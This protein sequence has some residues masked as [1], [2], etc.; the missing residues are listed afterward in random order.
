MGYHTNFSASPTRSVQLL[1]KNM[2]D[3]PRK[4]ND[5]YLVLYQILSATKS[6]FSCLRAV[7]VI[8]GL[9]GTQDPF[10]TQSGLRG[11]VSTSQ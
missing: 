1:M 11:Y 7:P 4:K 3:L 9:K 6:R 2:A 10:L 5:D 8:G